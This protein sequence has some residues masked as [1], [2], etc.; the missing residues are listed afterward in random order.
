MIRNWMRVRALHGLLFAGAATLVAGAAGCSSDKSEIHADPSSRSPDARGVDGTRLKMIV[1]ENRD[2]S[3]VLGG[4]YDTKIQKRCTPEV[5][6]DASVCVPEDVFTLPPTM[7]DPSKSRGTLLYSD[8]KCETLAGV[9]IPSYERA[10]AG[11][12]LVRTAPFGASASTSARCDTSSAGYGYYVT[13]P[14]ASTAGLYRSW[15]SCSP[16]APEA[17]S[18]DFALSMEPATKQNLEQTDLVTGT[19]QR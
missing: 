7:Y 9:I 10:C 8:A 2:G 13:K 18:S 16:Y 3:R 15:G 14:L 4:W 17:G 1:H 6:A 11:Y 12:G 5:V 19:V